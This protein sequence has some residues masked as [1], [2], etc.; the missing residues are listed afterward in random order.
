MEEAEEQEL[1]P[2]AVEEEEEAE[3]IKNSLS[4]LGVINLGTIRVSV[5]IVGRR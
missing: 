5:P 4:A 3:R 2:E 1:V